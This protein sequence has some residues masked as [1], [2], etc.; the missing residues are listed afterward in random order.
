MLLTIDAGNTNIVFGL[1]NHT[2][3]VTS[4]KIA[5]HPHKT[6]DELA[7]F[8]N[9]ALINYQVTT[10]DINGIIISSVVSS[11]NKNLTLLS[12]KYFKVEAMVVGPQLKSGIAIKIEQPK[13]L[14]SDLLVASVATLKKYG[15]N[16]L[17]IDMGTATSMTI[18]NNEGEFIGGSIHPGLET[19]IKA[20]SNNAAALPYIELKVPKQV[21]CKDTISCMQAGLLYGYASMIDGMINRF[22]QEYQQPL[23]VIL[24]GGNA[25]LVH[26]LLQSEVTYDPTLLF[27]GLRILYEKNINRI[28]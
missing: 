28:L 6:E 15:P 2:K 10:N 7:A 17:I 9:N 26:Q 14:G 18:I 19:S 21:I 24:T 11:L 1:F 16:C 5:T 12:K 3:L 25:L 4:F 8:I 20:L 23:K 13:A 22:N 27:D